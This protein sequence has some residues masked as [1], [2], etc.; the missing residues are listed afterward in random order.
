LLVSPCVDAVL[1]RKTVAINDLKLGC[2]EEKIA[3]V[4]V[5]RILDYVVN[6]DNKGHCLAVNLILSY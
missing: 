6:V 2:F 5:V 4:A 1:T 3:V